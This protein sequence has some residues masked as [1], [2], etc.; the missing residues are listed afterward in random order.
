MSNNKITITIDNKRYSVNKNATILEAARQNDIYIPTLCYH[1]ELSPYGGCRMCIV[2]V[3]GMR[4]FPTSCTTP[5]ADGMVIRTQTAQLQSIRSEILQLFMSEHTSSCLICEE[6]EKCKNFLGT[7]RK[8]GVTTGCRYCPN[9]EQCDLQNVVE[10]LNIKEINYPIFYRNQR[11]EKEDPF[12]NRD[13]NLCILCGRCIRMCQEVRLANVLAF[14][15]K[16]RNTVIGPAYSRT[17]YDSGCEFCGACVYVCPTGTLSE[18][19]IKWEGVPE[20]EQQT[21]CSFC[22]VGCQIRLLV[23]KDRVIGSLP[24]DDPLVNHAQLCV[25]G[26]FCI[27]E[28]VNSYKRLRFPYKTFN[29][30]RVNISWDQAEEIAVEKLASCAPEDFG[31][32]ISS[33]CTNEDLYIAQKFTRIAMK[34]PNIDCSARLFYG[35]G[36]NA[37]L[38]LA[39]KATTLDTVGKADLIVCIGLDARFGRSVVGVEIRK[40]IKSGAKIITIHPREHNLTLT[41]D[42][43][44]Q[45]QPGRELDMFRS[46]EK[47]TGKSKAPENK[48]QYLKQ[49]L[50]EISEM[51]NRATSL[52]F[53]T[54]SDFLTHNQNEILNLIDK[55]AQNIGA[56]IL[57]LPSHNNFFGSILMGVYPEILPDGFSSSNNKQIKLLNEKWK[58]NL[59]G[60]KSNWHS[61]QLNTGKK[62]KV[63]YMIGENPPQQKKMPADFIL[64]QNIYAPEDSYEAQL[65]LPAA[66]F[67]EINGTYINGEGRIQQLNRAVEPL[68]QSKPDWQIVCSIARKLNINGFEFK[69]IDEISREMSEVISGFEVIRN[70]TRK[71]YPLNCTAEL[72]IDNKK[73]SANKK[74]NSQYPLWLYVANSEHTHRGFPLSAHVDGAKKI[75]SEGYL[76]LNP[77]DARKYRIGKDDLVDVNSVNFKEIWPAKISA[78][79]PEGSLY[80]S[81]P[82]GGMININPRPVRIKKCSK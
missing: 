49:E 78:E 17:H 37:Y 1:K 55:I 22:G 47:L 23:K 29:N 18:K 73:K 32:L 80:I 21:T 81:L 82:A 57:P 65:A 45:P 44:L 72:E 24:V 76:I 50:Q 4:N 19:S 25:K 2:E 5:V 66:A 46:L 36:F 35:N 34:S 27:P 79:Q 10:H 61:G 12:Y 40:A 11:V 26:R 70:L 43:W 28:T 8:A 64:S 6:R 20:H 77:I 54:G 56:E 41:A 13:Y 9:D 58:A 62:L 53:L 30:N 48:T 39:K 69:S 3:E 67:T 42:K 52:V 60:V 71:P 16:G 68:G 15:N 74:N 7:I 59:P 75:F 38:N 33:N 31:L 63:L 51:F 14:K